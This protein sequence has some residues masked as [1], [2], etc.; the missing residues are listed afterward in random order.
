MVAGIGCSGRMTAY[1]DY[2]TVHGT[3]GRALAVA[4]GA[5]AADPCL[6]VIVVMGDGDCAAI[7]GNH[8]IHAARRNVDLTAMVFNNAIYGMTGGQ[9]SRDHVRG[10]H[11]DDEPVRQRRAGVRHLRAV[12]GRGRHLRGPRHR[13]CVREARGQIIAAGIIHRGFSFVEVDVST[14]PTYYGRQNNAGDGGDA[15]GPEG[16]SRAGRQVRAGAC[17]AARPVP[18][19]RA[20]SRR[21]RVMDYLER[22]RRRRG[23]PRG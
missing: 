13:L 11:L 5:K 18:R 10:R 21:A 7:G 8:L 20:P 9:M 1:L 14:C 17:A 12:A 22:V 4:T 19:R 23:C 16:A 6:Q 3:H 2:S 15:E